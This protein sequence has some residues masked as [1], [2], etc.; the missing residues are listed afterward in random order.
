MPAQEFL[1]SHYLAAFSKLAERLRDMACVV[2]YDVMNEPSRGYIGWRNLFS[3]ANYR[4]W[5]TPSPVQAMFL[6]SG[7]P[8][9]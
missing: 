3:S 7:L 4:Y 2:G 6:G 8:Q 1:Q 5:I 9:R